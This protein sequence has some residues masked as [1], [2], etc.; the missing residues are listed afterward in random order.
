MM[1]ACDRAIGPFASPELARRAFDLLAGKFAKGI[2]YDKSSARIKDI[3]GR[4]HL[5]DELQ[6]ISKACVSPYAGHEIPGFEELGL[7]PDKIYQLL[8]DPV[9]LAKAAPTFNGIPLAKYC[10]A[11][12]C[13][14]VANSGKRAVQA[15]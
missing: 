7:E 6:H 13:G 4:L 11:R 2:A 5:H 1:M 15:L 10:C 12:A 3:D 8:R 9:E 14:P